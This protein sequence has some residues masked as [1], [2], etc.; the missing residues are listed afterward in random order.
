[1]WVSERW[2]QLRDAGYLDDP[3]LERPRAETR[4]HTGAVAVVVALVVLT[5]VL[6]LAL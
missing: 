1:M 6:A 3:R 4:L 2:D 5:A